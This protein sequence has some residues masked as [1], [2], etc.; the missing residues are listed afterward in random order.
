MLNA[1]QIEQPSPI[2]H[3]F[4]ASQTGNGEAIARRLGSEA[5]QAGLSV[6]TQSLMQLK[7]IGRAH[8]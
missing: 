5:G 3:V 6:K 7:Q 1:V 2:L 8:V 4:Y